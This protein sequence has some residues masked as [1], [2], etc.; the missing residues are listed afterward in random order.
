MSSRV[1]SRMSNENRTLVFACICDTMEIQCVNAVSL[2]LTS[3][4]VQ[5]CM[6]LSKDCVFKQ[7]TFKTTICFI[8]YQTLDI[9]FL[10]I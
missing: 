7:Y 5:N 1:G 2:Q 6:F 9:E 3:P 8:K 4:Y 10:V